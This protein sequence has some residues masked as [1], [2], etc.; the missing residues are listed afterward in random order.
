MKASEF[1]SVIKEYMLDLLEND[2]DV[3]GAI[4]EAIVK[5][6]GVLTE[7]ARSNP[8][9]SDPDNAELYDKLMLVGQGQGTGL[10]HRG[11]TV[12]APNMGNGFRSASAL[13]E[14]TVKAYNKLG[15]GWSPKTTSAR[16]TEGRREQPQAQKRENINAIMGMFGGPVE[17]EA[18]VDVTE[19]VS[20]GNDQA[21]REE[22]DK[23]VAGAGLPGLSEIMMDT[24]KTTLMDQDAKNGIGPVS[25]GASMVVATSTPEELFGKNV[26][27]WAGL[28][29][30]N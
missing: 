3:Q 22:V 24:A 27:S 23:A 15:G 1:K 21:L 8:E 12:R 11:K 6:A 4:E 29:F 28:A 10:K 25:D 5:H 26:E 13:K 2:E 30:G 16:L 17:G 18:G 19:A 14:W 7:A 20:T 9:V